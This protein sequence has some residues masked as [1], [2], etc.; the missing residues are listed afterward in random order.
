M[1]AARPLLPELSAAM[2]DQ[3]NQAIGSPISAA[4]SSAAQGRVVRIAV[5][6]SAR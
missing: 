6:S 2:A 1:V 4:S 3:I 5:K